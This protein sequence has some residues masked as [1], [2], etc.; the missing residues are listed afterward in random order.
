MANANLVGRLRWWP[1]RSELWHALRRQRRLAGC[2]GI[3]VGI[4][5]A[6]AVWIALPDGRHEAQALLHLKPDVSQPGPDPAFE[7]F[8]QTQARLLLSRSVFERVAADP[9]VARHLGARPVRFLED[10]T[11]TRWESPELL[12]V[13]MTGDDPVLLQAALDVLIAEYLRD[14]VTEDAIDRLK[15]RRAIEE[16]EGSS[17]GDDQT[18]SD[19]RQE[20]LRLELADHAGPRVLRREGVTVAA[21]RNLVRKVVRSAGAFVAG[22]LAAL[23]A[24]TLAEWS[25]RRVDSAEHAAKALGL[26]HLG[27][28]RT[29]LCH[30]PGSHSPQA[31]AVVGT[32]HDDGPAALAAGLASDVA[33][34]GFRALLLAGEPSPDSPRAPG[35][36]ELLL[37]EIDVT[38]VV[39]PT[40][41]SGLW[42]IPIGER[43]ERVSAAMAQGH[44]LTALLDRLR[45]QYDL[46]VIDAGPILADATLICR[47]MDGVV[48]SVKRDVSRL[49]HIQT[50]VE[51]VSQCGVPI[52]GVAS[53]GDLVL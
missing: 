8:K 40:R 16:M 53:T 17:P 19:R 20:L 44:A 37:Q 24:V 25:R 34:M 27:D 52:M 48:V 9:T 50:T 26:P 35:F 32:T 28:V 42:M 1:T 5:A 51:A 13:T 30:A 41:V 4:A 49:P 21:N 10:A 22:L 43:S 23:A 2:L 12:A 45:R 38:E 33:R 29:W 14:A 39:L 47:Y 18:R 36:G 7:G 11:R 6:V 3:A 15:Q 46:V 31:I